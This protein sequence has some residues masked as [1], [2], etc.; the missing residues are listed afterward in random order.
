VAGLTLRS[1]QGYDAA[2][3]LLLGVRRH[4]QPLFLRVH[5]ED[6][7]LRMGCLTAPPRNSAAA[8][9]TLHFLPRGHTES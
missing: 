6:G 8:H 5:I 2:L 1:G 4:P 7:L 3:S 9:G